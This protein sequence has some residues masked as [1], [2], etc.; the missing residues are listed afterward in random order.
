[1]KHYTNSFEG[2]ADFSV[3]DVWFLL[4]FVRKGGHHCAVVHPNPLSTPAN[5]LQLSPVCA[6]NRRRPKQNGQE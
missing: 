3:D 6:V 4:F 2:G 1:M 5:P